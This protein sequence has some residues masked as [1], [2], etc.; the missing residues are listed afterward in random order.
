[1]DFFRRATNPWGQD[2]LLGIAWDLMWAAIIV[3]IAFVIVHAVYMRFWPPEEAA[4][5]LE[6]GP[7]VPE[8]SLPQR[9]VRHNGPARA[10]H[11][12]TT[13]AMFALLIT[14][15]FPVIGIRFPWVTIHWIAGI[16][17]LA[18][19]IYHIVHTWFWEDWHSMEIDREEIKEG[20]DEVK[21]FLHQSAP[22]PT[23]PGKYPL[24]H[25]L[26]HHTIALVTIAAV[27]TGVLMMARIDTP[28]WAR[29]PYL[30]SDQ[31]WGVVYVVH[32][33]GGV[34]LITLT[35]AHIYFAVRPDKWWLT[36]SMIRG[37]I[38]RKE[39]TAHHDPTRWAV[40]GG[41]LGLAGIGVPGPPGERVSDKQP[42]A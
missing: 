22:P 30:L 41:S 16:A 18:L 23:K 36:R 15:F 7:A 19:M 20:T 35:L 17:L 1:M 38:W 21:R 32:G 29:H 42:V 40:N 6:G 39:Y 27:V 33:V 11:W 8:A 13:L 2:V 28:F 12:L 24:D 4:G 9:I 26:Y 3:G 5:A 37:W 31:L 25:K 14:A 10:F 34:A